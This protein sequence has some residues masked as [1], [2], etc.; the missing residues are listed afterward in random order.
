MLYGFVAQE[1]WALPRSL[2][3]EPAVPSRSVRVLRDVHTVTKPPNGTFLRTDPRRQAAQD[4]AHKLV[5]QRAVVSRILA[6][7]RRLLGRRQRT[8]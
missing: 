1:P 5:S 8:V 3:V 4:C 6:E 7:G 2:G